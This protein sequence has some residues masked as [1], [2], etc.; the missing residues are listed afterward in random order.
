MTLAQ[1]GHRT[2]KLDMCC[3]QDVGIEILQHSELISSS[4]V[5]PVVPM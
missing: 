2:S 5:I 4:F 3:H 1:L